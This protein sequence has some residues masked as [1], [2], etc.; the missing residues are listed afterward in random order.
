MSR[1]TSL[2]ARIDAFLAERRR[3]G[4]KLHSWDTLLSG[5]AR[6]VASRHHRGA[7][8]VS[9]RQSSWPVERQP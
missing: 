3:L 7:L 8:T 2:Q 4:F 1:R 6:Y 5:F 9:A